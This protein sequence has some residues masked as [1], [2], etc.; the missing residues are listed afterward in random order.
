MTTEKTEMV[1]YGGLFVI[2]ILIMLTFSPAALPVVKVIINFVFLAPAAI[3]LWWLPAFTAFKLKHPHRWA[4]LIAVP[5]A[6]LAL[7]VILGLVIGGAELMAP[8]IELQDV[9]RACQEWTDGCRV[10]ERTANGEFN[11]SNIGIACQPTGGRCS[12]HSLHWLMYP[13]EH[14]QAQ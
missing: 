12:R 6:P 7:A 9:G 5:L 11:C 8:T 2:A 13:T 14:E 1:L 4:I 10:C 3:Y